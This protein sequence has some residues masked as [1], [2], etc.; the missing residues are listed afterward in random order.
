MTVD[1]KNTVFLPK[2]DFAMKANLAKREPDI[3]KQWQSIDLYKTLRN[4]AKDRE[5]F[6]LHFGP[7]YANGNIHIGHALT[8]TLKDIVNKTYQILGY[9]APLVPGWDCHGLPIE[10]KIEESYRDSGLD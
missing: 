7:P 6:I 8:E 2:T 1:Y 9:D 3:L 5:K 10:W 4:Q